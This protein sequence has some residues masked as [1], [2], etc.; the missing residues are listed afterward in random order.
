MAGGDTAQLARVLGPGSEDLLSSGDPVADKSDRAAFAAAYQKAH[1]LVPGDGE[2]MTLVVGDKQWPF[3]IPIVK[4]GGRWHFDAAQG[5]E[6]LVYRRIGRNELGAISVCRG[7]V[8]AERDYAAESRD[9]DPAGIYALKLV[10]DEGMHNGLYWPTEDSGAP[11]PAGPFV[12]SAAAEGYRAGVRTP[13]HGYYYRLLYKQGEHAP[14]GAREYFKNGL[15][16]EGFAM[17][18]WPAEYQVS[19]VMTFIVNQ[20]GTVFQKD[21]GADTKTTVAAITAF[22]PDDTW[23]PVVDAGPT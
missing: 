16:T 8:D 23:K 14:G 18:A 21:L 7:F 19:G 6:E 11:S 15:L 1:A 20:D 5:A 10:S 13:Y 22:D 17:L 12:A 9:G 2:T 4:R 3:P